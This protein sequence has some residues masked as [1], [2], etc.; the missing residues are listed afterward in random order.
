MAQMGYGQNYSKLE[1]YYEKKFLGI[2]EGLTAQPIVWQEVVDN[3][4][5][6]CT[7]TMH[8]FFQILHFC[9]GAG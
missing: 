8:N 3:G 5:K 7:E 1:A 2:I 9:E 4:V 6:V